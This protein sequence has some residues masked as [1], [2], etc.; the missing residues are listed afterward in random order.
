[1]HQDCHFKNA[2]RII[3]IY[4]YINKATAQFESPANIRLRVIYLHKSMP[5]IAAE[6]H[7]HLAPNNYQDKDA[8]AIYRVDTLMLDRIFYA[9]TVFIGDTHG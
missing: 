8:Y 7:Q 4:I 9:F 5:E 6:P 3:Y 2:T 1:M